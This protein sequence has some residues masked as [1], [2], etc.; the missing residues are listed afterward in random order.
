LQIHVSTG[1]AF[2][3]DVICGSLLSDGST[4]DISMRDVIVTRSMNIER[5]T[6]DVSFE[7]CDAME[8]TIQTGTGDVT[9]SLLSPKRFSAVSRTGHVEVPEDAVAGRCSITTTTGD[10]R[11]TCP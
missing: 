1:K 11:I 7:R 4:G 8:L 10:I 2:L 3:S 6:G 5:S 9:G